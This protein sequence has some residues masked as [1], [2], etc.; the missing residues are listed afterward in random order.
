LNLD[1][2]QYSEEEVRS[3]LEQVLGAGQDERINNLI[4][5]LLK[6]GIVFAPEP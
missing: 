4:E 6:V 2:G 5:C 1:L 3:T